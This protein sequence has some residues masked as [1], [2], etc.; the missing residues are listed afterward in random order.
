M[1]KRVLV[2]AI[3]E[4]LLGEKSQIEAGLAATNK[5]IDE[6][7]GAMQSHSDTTKFQMNLVANTIARSLQE[8]EQAIF[9]LQSFVGTPLNQT[10]TDSVRLGAVV[11]L[12]TPDGAQKLAYAILPGGAGT[13][14][15]FEG[16]SLTVITPQSPLTRRFIG[17]KVGDK[18]EVT[19]GEFPQTMIVTRVE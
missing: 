11:E 17:K 2:S 12:I 16:W 18:V 13:D 4:K 6:A 1:D 7:P 8:K 3:I 19:F 5:G 10:A 15:D 9:H 14:I